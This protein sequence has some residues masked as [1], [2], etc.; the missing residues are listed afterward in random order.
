MEIGLTF[1]NQDQAII[2][3]ADGAAVPHVGELLHMAGDVGTDGAALVG[4][5]RVAS[6]MFQVNMGDKFNGPT[7]YGWH[8]QLSE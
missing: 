1:P 5:Y 3:V 2:K 4:T 6:R 7:S 8:L